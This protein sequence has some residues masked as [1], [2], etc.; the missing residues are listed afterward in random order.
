MTWED[1]LNN[2]KHWLSSYNI[3]EV[4]CLF[5]TKQLLYWPWF[6]NRGVS[7]SKKITAITSSDLHK[8]LD[9]SSVNI[10]VSFSIIVIPE[11]SVI[12]AWKLDQ[13]NK[14]CCQK[15]FLVK[16]RQTFCLSVFS[17][18]MTIM[19]IYPAITSSPIYMVYLNY[20]RYIL[21][22]FKLLF[23]KKQYFSK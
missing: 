2:E 6:I 18:Y 12:I 3:F 17:Y 23:F 4:L 20:S 8:N 14:Q 5:H 21:S 1:F 16:S 11:T 13:R 10:K 7:S 15:N 19:S 9:D 22:S